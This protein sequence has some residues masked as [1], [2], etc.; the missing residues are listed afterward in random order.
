MER[1]RSVWLYLDQHPEML[2]SGTEILHV[3]PE[4]VLRNRLRSV[5]GADYHGGD[6]T[7][8]FGP[9][10][11]DVTDLRFPDGSMDI[12]VCNHVL[13]HVPDDHRAMSEIRRVLRPDGWALLLVLDLEGETVL[14]QTDEDLTV[15]S[16]EERQRRFG[17]EDHVRRY[18]WDYL[19]RLRTAGLEPEVVD[20]AKIFS[21]E[22]IERS[23]L[24]KFG[25][26]EPLIFCRPGETRS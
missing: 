11:I 10:R 15:M 26:I 3:A 4:N 25:S 7:A 18:G 19:N 24:A 5:P 6:L 8:E 1:H 22:V 20:P 9:E 12:V 13:E 21:A 2:P 14:D 16:P 23:R 17:Q